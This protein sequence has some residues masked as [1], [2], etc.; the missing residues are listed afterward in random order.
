MYTRE[1]WQVFTLYLLHAA[2]YIFAGSL[3]L[4]VLKEDTIAR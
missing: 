4:V 1:W 3:D 2:F